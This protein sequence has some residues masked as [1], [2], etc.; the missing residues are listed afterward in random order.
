[1]EIKEAQRAREV[2]DKAAEQQT[3]ATLHA[4][5]EIKRQRLRAESAEELLKVFET[6]AQSLRARSES[7]EDRVRRLESSLRAEQ[8]RAERLALDVR[9]QPSA[10]PRVGTPPVAYSAGPVQSVSAGFG[11]IVEAA[12]FAAQ[13]MAEER[14]QADKLATPVPRRPQYST[15]MP[16]APR[17]TGKGIPPPPNGIHGGVI[18]WMRRL[19]GCGSRNVPGRGGHYY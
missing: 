3:S 13:R 5:A 14:R 7:A 19:S 1:M 15:P 17:R 2:A 16:P 18:G 6:D 4:E 9:A 11:D 10:A 8:E 12:C